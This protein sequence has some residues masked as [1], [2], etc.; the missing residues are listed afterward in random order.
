MTVEDD[1]DEDFVFAADE[2]IL[3]KIIGQASWKILVVDDDPDIHRVTKLNLQDI[4]FDNKPV[5]FLHAYSSEEAKVLLANNSDIALILLDVVMEERD[6]GLKFVKYV[7]EEMGNSV[8]R[9]ILRTGQPGQAPQNQVV[10][11]YD[12]NDYKEKSELT[13]DRFF[14]AI[15]LA[16]RS[17]KALNE[18]QNS[19]KLV[20]LQA[21]AANRFVPHDFLKILQKSDLTDIEIGD[22]LEKEVTV[23]FLDIKSFSTIAESLTSSE[24]YQFVNEYIS[25]IQPAI[26]ANQGFIDK[27]IGDAIMAVFCSGPQTAI[28]AAIDMHS[29]MQEY[30]VK[31]AEQSKQK[32][33]MGIGINTGPVAIGTVGFYDRM[34]I[35]VLSDVVNITERVEK[36]NRLFHTDVLITEDAFV[37]LPEK[38]PFL[39]RWIGHIKTKGR[40]GYV[41]IYE[42]YNSSKDADLKTA[43]KEHFNRAMEAYNNKNFELAQNIFVRLY[44]ENP[45]DSVVSYYLTILNELQNSK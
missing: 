22:Y 33:E 45:M 43:Q 15:I 32:I 9:I 5:I 2:P 6:S 40:A 31:R 25:Y 29:F 11:M 37:K 4:T 34:E 44:E 30:N 14:S 21:A 13:L 1:D 26:V 7:R 38:H 24:L 19:R 42:V 27:Y 23:L 17:Y 18:L 28:Q 16:F 20:E 39:C 3:G 36:M 12:I 8:V 41:S 35:T 10:L